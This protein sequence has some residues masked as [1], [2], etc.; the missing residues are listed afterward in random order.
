MTKV[1][2]IAIVENFWREVWQQP[3]NPDAI[4]RLVHE[5]V[6]IT[7]GGRDIVGREPFKEWVRDFQS[8]VRDFQFHVVETFQSHDGN[9]VVSRWR[10]TGRNNGLMG[11]QPNDAPFEM[12]GTAVWEVGPDGLL[13]HNWVERSAYEVYG[14]ISQA[15]GRYNVF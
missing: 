3:Q 13:R 6:V 8:K 7:S 9:R 5:E 1:D 2:G 4:D 12:T 15:N 10:V 14:A 11:T